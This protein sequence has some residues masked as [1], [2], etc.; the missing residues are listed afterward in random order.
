M[1]PEYAEISKDAAGNF[2][3]DNNGFISCICK[4]KIYNYL[5]TY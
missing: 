2:L 3:V 1:N 5:Y 4:G